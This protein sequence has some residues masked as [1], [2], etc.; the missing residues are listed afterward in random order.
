[1][2]A[3]MWSLASKIIAVVIAT[4]YLTG[5]VLHD[6]EINRG[7]LSLSILL[8]IPLSLI[9]FPEEIGGY[10]GGAGHGGYIDAATPSALMSFV[11]WFFLIGMPVVL[12]LLV[13]H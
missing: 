5:M 2:M 6:H 4:A 8:L 11:G 13:R 9:W 7:V 10:I 1:M 3:G 12:Y